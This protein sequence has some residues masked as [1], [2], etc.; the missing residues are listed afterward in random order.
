[1]EAKP[2]IHVVVFETDKR[3]TNILRGRVN[4]RDITGK[5][6]SFRMTP[7]KAKNSEYKQPQKSHLQVTRKVDSQ[8]NWKEKKFSEQGSRRQG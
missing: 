7:E 2:S 1:M 8:S 4:N 3:R 6:R 5:P